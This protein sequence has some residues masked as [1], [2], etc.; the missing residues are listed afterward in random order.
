MNLF[1]IAF[2]ACTGGKSSAFSSSGT[3][4]VDSPVSNDTDNSS[5]TDTDTDSEDSGED[6]GSEDLGTAPVI[7]EVDA[8]FSETAEGEPSI[9]VTVE[10]DDAEGDILNGSVATVLTSDVGS[11]ESVIPIDGNEAEMLSGDLVFVLMEN[12]DNT[13]EYTLSVVVTDEAGNS[14][15]PGTD[16]ISP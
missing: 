10:L 15:L 5:D 16:D 8:I 7:R 6:S 1:L 13:L 14:S 2:L 3:T 12:I 4:D 11:D 9:A